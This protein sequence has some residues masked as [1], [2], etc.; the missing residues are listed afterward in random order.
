MSQRGIA[1][2]YPPPA[3]SSSVLLYGFK[4]DLNR[5]L[6]ALG[7]LAPVHEL[8]DVVAFN[9][10]HPVQTL[11]YGQSIALAALR[12]DDSPGSAD[13][14]RYLSDRTRDLSLF[15]GALD[16]A[17]AGPD[18]LPDTGDEF[19]ALLFPAN[20]GADAPARAGYPSVCVPG[21]FIE[22]TGGLPPRPFGVTFTGRAF[23]E[24][25]LLA[26][27]YAF[28]QATH[29]RRPPDTTPPLR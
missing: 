22:R 27:A 18:A 26:L 25:R 10:A 14:Q 4:H 17:F 11:R 1:V 9:V 13:T 19:D 23:S 29:H 20:I 6:A 3:N 5:Y 16:E 15:R 7:P 21:G 28:E 8:A 2:S 12:I 24:P